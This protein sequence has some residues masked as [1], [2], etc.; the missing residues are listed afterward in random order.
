MQQSTPATKENWHEDFIKKLAESLK[1]KV[2]VEL[3]LYQC[4]LFNKIVPYAENLFGV[5]INPEAGRWMTK[6]EKTLFFHGTT[7]EFVEQVKSN[8][9]KIDLL[10][11]DADHCK[12]SVLNDFW[13]YFPYVNDHGIILLHDTYPKNLQYTDKGYC[14][15]AYLAINELKNHQDEFELMT[16]PIH[17]GLTL[18]RKRKTQLSWENSS[19][20]GTTEKI[21]N[22][23]NHLN[24]SIT[25]PAFASKVKQMFT[26]ESDIQTIVEIGALDAKDSQYFKEVFPQA[27][28]Y[29][30]EALPDNFNNYM[31]DLKDI[32]S[33]NAVVSNIDGEVDF[34]KK[35]INGIHGIFNRGDEYGTEVIKL[36][37]YRFET[38][39]KKY[40]IE[41][42]DML[43]L[44]VEGATV[45]ALEGMGELLTEIKIMHLESESYPF[46]KGQ[47]LHGEVVKF[48]EGKGFSLLELT[49]FPIQKGRLQFD[50][51]WINNKYFYSQTITNKR[52]IKEVGKITS[53]YKIICI[54]QIYNELRK[55]N[56]ERFWEYL[57]PVVDGLVVYDDGSTDGSYEYL[58]DKAIFILKGGDNDFV[59][60][61]NHKKV[62]LE[63]ALELKPDF[64]LWLDADEVLTA[65]AAAE[66]QNLC[67]H[68]DENEIDGMS[69]HEINLWRSNS[70]QRTDN[71]YNDGWFVRLWRVTPD[72]KF[73]SQEA[74]LHQQQYP[75]SIK[76]VEKANKVAVIHYGFAS[77]RSLAFKYL[78]YRAH[79]QSGWALERLLDEKTL[80]LKYVSK[81]IFPDGLFVEDPQPEKRSFEQAVASLEQFR[82]IVFKPRIS[83]VCMIYKSVEWLEFVYQQ[84]LKYT[85]LKDKEFFF[86]ANDASEDVLKY[87]EENYIPHFVWNNSEEQKKEWYINNV[88]RAWNFGAE[89]AKGDYLLFVNSDMAFTPEWFENL[90]NK[91]DGSNCV[92]SRLVES[93]KLLSGKY[94]VSKNFGRSVVDYNE[95]GFIEFAKS[96][97]EET[98]NDGGLFMPLLI[99]KE[100]FMNVG[101]YPEGNII[102]TTD[103]LKPVIAKQNELCVSGDVVLMQKL[104]LKGI[105]QKTAFDSLVYHFQCGEMDSKGSVNTNNKLNRVVI[106]NDYLEGRMGEKTMWGF[107]LEGLP[108][109]AGVDMDILGSTENFTENAS[110]YISK[111]FPNSSIVIQNATFIDI[112]NHNRFTI[113][114][115]QDN[116]RAMGRKSYQQ[117]ANLKRANILVTNSKLTALSY[118]DYNFEIIP[119]GV[120]D[121]LFKPMDKEALRQEFNFPNKKTGIF[122]GDFSETKGW[123][124]VKDLINNHSEIF[125]I[126]VSKDKQE[127]KRDNCRT[128]NRIAQDLLAKLLNCSDF[129]VLGSPVETQ[130]LAA[131]EAALCDLPIIM[132]NTGIFADFT[133]SEKAKVGVFGEDFENALSKILQKN[134]T[135]RELMIE[136]G[137]TIN[138]MVNQ[139]KAVIQKARIL[140]NSS[141]KELAKEKLPFFTVVVPTYNQAQYLGEALDSLLAQTFQNWEAIIVN[142]GSND[143]T[144]HVMDQYRARD[145][146]FKFFNKENGG[147]SSALNV[148][149]KNA[150]GEWLCWL[151]SDDWFEKDKLET[152]YNAILENP[153]IKFFRSHWSL[154]YDETKKRLETGVWLLEPKPQFQVTSYFITNY[155]HGNSIAIHKT[156]FDNVGLF[157]ETMRQGQD[158]DMWVR[159]SSKYKS[160]FINKRTCVTRIHK[161]QTTNTFFE[162]GVFDSTR[163]LIDFL[164]NNQFEALF[165]FYNLK[166]PNNVKNVITEILSITVKYDS[167]LYK[168][169]YTTA[170]IDSMRDWMFR[171]LPSNQR[172][173]YFELL[174]QKAKEFLELPLNEN[175]KKVIQK[176]YSREEYKYEKYDFIQGI[177]DYIKQLLSNGEQKYAKALEIYLLKVSPLYPLQPLKKY[178]PVLA[179]Y[180]QNGKFVE[181]KPKQIIS[182]SVN[183]HPIS[184]NRIV[185]RLKIKCHQCN[186]TFKINFDYQFLPTPYNEGFICPECKTGMHFSDKNFDKDLT[187]FH[188]LHVKTSSN[189]N[190]SKPKVAFLLRDTAT[191]GGGNK[192]VFKYMDWLKKLGCQ[193]VIFSYNPKPDWIKIDYDYFQ[194]TD[195]S[196]INAGNID[197]FIVVSIFDLPKL[198]NEIP[199]NKIVHLCQGYEGYHYGSDYNS[200]LSDKH[201]LTKL[202]AIPVKNIVVSKHLVDLFAS[203]FKKHVEYVP[204]GVDHKIFRL[205]EG[206]I[207]AEKSILF[208]GNIYH[209][210]KGFVFLASAL[211]AIQN[212][213]ERVDNLKLYVVLGRNVSEQ[214]MIKKELERNTGC[215]VELKFKL[216]STEMSSLMQKV[217]LVACSS[218]YEGF[219]LPLI[220]A[221]AV[222]TPVI[223]TDNMGAESFCSNNFN[224]FVVKYGD[225]HSLTDRI[226]AIIKGDKHLSQIINNARKTSLQYS[227]YYSAQDFVKSFQN[228]LRREFDD[229]KIEGLL[230]E[231]IIPELQNINEVFESQIPARTSIIIPVYNQLKHT[232]ECLESLSKSLNEKVKLIVVNNAS[233]DGTKKYLESLSDEKFN[234]V[235]INNDENFGFPKAVNQGLSISEGAYIIV[236]N[237]DIVFTKGWLDKMI[238]VAESETKIGIVGTMSNLANGIQMDKKIKY[239][240]IKEMHKYAEIISKKNDDEYLNTP[241]IDFLCALIKK[242]VVDKIGGLDERYSPGNYDDDDYCLR[243]N[244]AGFKTVVAQNVFI[245]HHGSKTFFANVQQPLASLYEINLQKFVQKWGASPDELWGHIK[246]VIQRNYSYPVNSNRFIQ[247]WERAKI[248]ISEKEY[249]FALESIIEAIAFY[250]QNNNIGAEIEYSG[251]IDLAGNIALLTGDYETA[252]KYF[253][254][255]LQLVPDSS[256]ACVG[257]GE[258]FF[259][260]E[261]FE[262]AKTMFEWGVKNDSQNEVAAEKLIRVNE[263]LGLDRNNNSLVSDTD[264][265]ENFLRSAI[266]QSQALVRD[267]KISEAVYLLESNEAKLNE[268]L[269][270]GQEVLIA[271]DYF[272][273]IGFMNLKLG[274]A[275]KAHSYF[276]MALN[277]DTASSEACIGLGE[278][279]FIKEKNE[280]AKTMLEWGIKNNPHNTAAAELLSRVNISLGLEKNHNS[281]LIGE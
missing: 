229:K 173:Q 176:I 174:E 13:N 163:A 256:F 186:S 226:L 280:A 166:D 212:S 250:P 171:T 187:E 120:D 48:L 170:L 264:E 34:F 261:Q 85:D 68:M 42:I 69:F 258:V 6:S 208:V 161:G 180:P 145:K 130:C 29:A 133:E 138:G 209:S 137:F 50:S 98:L 106:A 218:W 79:G 241:R 44:D 177:I 157:N 193:I 126:L 158:F 223:T 63:K 80:Q 236:A 114:Y 16:I 56:L 267:G 72:L 146:R 247:Y 14:G 12:E 82:E 51:I 64:I 160:H 134:F 277:L 36:K 234:L 204:N 154:F 249:P 125:W 222:G 97:S 221:M 127:Y 144:L 142:D 74:G 103:L 149:I 228:L 255:E 91:L 199:I 156:V 41:K 185:H 179:C 152:H 206:K 210:L 182:W 9:L 262:N 58:L 115:L 84:V 61:I 139:W 216:S 274:D 59:N 1:P 195:E 87:L 52:E 150:V 237:N 35:R 198:L 200:V 281:F 129:F 136:K 254:E 168:C 240:T 165:P 32:T 46:F 181:L 45:E 178:S 260:Q 75:S 235:I 107:L 28:V 116:L 273:T 169:G 17:P 26:N 220:E 239:R 243:S 230:S 89:K 122:V 147:V 251:L 225:L 70:W 66:I 242:E 202:H 217:S 37:S 132:R 252:K 164:N 86:I 153:D 211:R 83:I 57:Q 76:K 159:I 197:L 269:N 108:N 101:G 8:N 248:Q 112:L 175:L 10:F 118:P 135:P 49:S 275:D 266:V 15:D 33:I 94:G 184:S 205:N 11:I 99:K 93:G 111:N 196:S 265:L 271:A 81:E 259:A 244:I 272:N 88:Y 39:A 232:K 121:K 65:N 38:L 245:H 128:F 104:A 22:L 213:V 141:V 162:G 23:E 124:K 117:E 62:L 143:N 30:V 53:Q 54:S 270:N 67:K 113:C 92:A 246:P 188:R 96:I 214:Q 77:D 102:P 268:L 47:K 224:S 31:K 155:N 140:R 189:E 233:T 119:I 60:E 167:F 203:K 24:K 78:V 148:G 191:V 276:E 55:E 40:G 18:I 227:E 190:H 20:N 257:L 21:I 109:S 123:A 201:I 231:Y 3:G 71:S 27:K 207:S 194:I 192:I 219:S 43:K 238:G 5:D 105:Y 7:D 2:Y 278:V 151:S 253:E 172:K 25:M 90:F 279:F 100:H 73:I 131:I 110:N 4:E 263:L 183:P 19:E 95:N 215:N